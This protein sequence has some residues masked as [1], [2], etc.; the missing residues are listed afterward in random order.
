MNRKSWVPNYNVPLWARRSKYYLME[1]IAALA[2]LL[3]TTFLLDR[4]LFALMHYLNDAEATSS[5]YDQMNLWVLSMLLVVLP[6]TLL[7][8]KRTRFEE[9]DRPVVATT[10]LRRFFLY[11]FMLVTLAATVSFAIATVYSIQIILFGAA[12]VSDT[13]LQQT[14]PAL[15]AAM[16]HGYV[17]RTFMRNNSVAQIKEF[18]A[19]LGMVG[20][21]LFA[22]LL[23]LS[24]LQAR[25]TLIDEKTSKDLRAISVSVDDY[26][27]EHG[28][29]PTTLTQLGLDKSVTRRGEKHGY[30]YATRGSYG[31]K[32]CAVFKAQGVGGDDMDT[33]I[34]AKRAIYPAPTAHNFYVH[35][36]GNHCFELSAGSSVSPLYDD[37]A[38]GAS[39]PYS[40]PE[41]NTLLRPGSSTTY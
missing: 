31:Y 16:I 8:Y 17:F 15:A 27:R 12:E 32:L 41:L 4:V 25:N 40:A 28:K 3:M 35:D 2:G 30:S 26:Y 9:L 1:F 6:V 36:K 14:I 19:T 23:I 37:S 38:T 39:E 10:K 33:L 29:L 18:A 22:A 21:I 11:T 20:V 13:L 5:T 34:S 24:S 7:F